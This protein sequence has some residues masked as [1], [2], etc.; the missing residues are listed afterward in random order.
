MFHG[1]AKHSMDNVKRSTQ[2]LHIPRTPSI[3]LGRCYIFHREGQ[4]FHG[5][6]KYCTDNVKCSTEV[7]N[8]ARRG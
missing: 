8:I 7:Q 1:G 5:G 4:M 3:I 6:A 2:V